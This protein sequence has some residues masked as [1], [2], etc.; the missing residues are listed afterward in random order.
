MYK[1]FAL[2][3]KMRPVRKVRVSLLVH[4]GIILFYLYIFSSDFSFIQEIILINYSFC[5]AMRNSLH[6]F[7]VYFFSKDSVERVFFLFSFG[8]VPLKYF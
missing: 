5:N 4:I 7:K 1:I 6:N 8:V 3:I 2:I